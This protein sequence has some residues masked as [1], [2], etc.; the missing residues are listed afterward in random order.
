M[1]CCSRLLP[2]RIRAAVAGMLGTLVLAACGSA[3]VV[4]TKESFSADSPYQKKV[5]V[6]AATACEA[7]RRALLGDGYVID[8]ANSDNVKGRKAYRSEGDR[9]TFIEM[10]VVCDPDPSGSSLYAN[11][12]LSTYDVKKS[13][14]SAS[15]GVSAIGSLSLPIGQS[16]DSMVKISDETIND[17]DFYH[18]FFVAVEAVLVD[19]KPET[20]PTALP[21]NTGRGAMSEELKTKARHIDSS[22]PNDVVTPPAGPAPARLPPMDIQNG[23]SSTPPLATPQTPPA[24]PAVAPHSAPLNIAPLLAPVTAPSSMPPADQA[25][26]PVAAPAVPPQTVPPGDSTPAAPQDPQQTAPPTPAP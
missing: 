5:G 10:S 18:R 25:T 8:K 20:P 9:S 15:V 19:I 21:D 6:G 1:F 16:A 24:A 12:L 2:N 13:A 3:P 11:G 22:L 4:Y 14:A 26:P 23:A 17:R 7:A